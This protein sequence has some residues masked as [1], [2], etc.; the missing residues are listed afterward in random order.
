MTAMNREELIAAL[1]D[2]DPD[3]AAVLAAV[4]IKRRD[5]S[6]SRV[7]AA[8]ALTVCVVVGALVARQETSPSST[9][10]ADGCASISV[11]QTLAEAKASGASVVIAT[12]TLTG[13]VASEGAVYNGLA[14]HAVRTLSGPAIAS[15]TLTWVSD[16]RGPDG[17]ALGAD[18]GALWAPDGRLFA[19]VWPKAVTGQTMG[20][21]SRVAPIVND[22]VILSSAG[23][24]DASGL[25]SQ[26]Y[27]GPLA[28]I[29]GSDSYARAKPNGF[30][31]VAL[32]TIEALAAR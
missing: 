4:R 27:D 14:L 19:I 13:Q 22:Q 10:A 21:T 24:W 18:A 17:A 23:C 30:H 20:D 1:A 5:R 16:G 25:Q 29:P 28:E 32:S 31:A 12:G 9:P 8:A 7:L 11:Q 15:G 2:H 26:P 6:R 3:E